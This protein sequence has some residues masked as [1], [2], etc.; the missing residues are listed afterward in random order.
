MEI[1]E[2]N[3]R[4]QPAIRDVARRSLEASYS[5]GPRAITGAIEEWYDQNRLRN[6]VSDDDKLVLVADDGGQVVGFSESVVTGEQTAQLLWLHIDPNYRGEGHGQRLFDA[7][8]DRL[9]GSGIDTLQGRVLADNQAGTAFYEAQGLTHVGEE[10]VEINGTSYAEYVYANVDEGGIEA[11]KTDGRT[12]YV[13]H[14]STE[15]GS[16]APFYV[17]YNQPGREEI[18]G[19]WCSRCSDLANAMDAMGRIQCDGCGNARK[20]TRWDAAYL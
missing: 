10:E 3:T 7:T 9:G 8:R 19:Y 1:R 13:N 20:P 6:I 15:T 17:V 4:D 12:V 14:D 5:L 18:Y 16:I 2:A 11:V